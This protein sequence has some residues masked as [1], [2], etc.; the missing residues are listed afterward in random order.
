MSAD[1]WSPTLLFWVAYRIKSGKNVFAA[2]VSCQ[3]TLANMP[4]Q[5]SPSPG[6]NQL[7]IVHIYSTSLKHLSQQEAR[8]PTLASQTGDEPTLAS[9]TGDEASVNLSLLKLDDTSLHRSKSRLL[10]YYTLRKKKIQWGYRILNRLLWSLTGRFSLFVEIK[11]VYKLLNTEIPMMG[12][13]KRNIEIE[14]D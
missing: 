14:P 9:Q 11:Y 5:R 1:I 6:A 12:T 2:A 10:G 4:G 7:F 8:S 13:P 3:K